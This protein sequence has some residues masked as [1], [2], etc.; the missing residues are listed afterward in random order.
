MTV[1]EIHPVPER[2]PVARDVDGWTAVMGD[3]AKLA[4]Y[5]ADT[6]LVPA[7]LRGRPAAIAA[8]IL[9]GRE[10]GLPPMTALR[11]SYV[12]AGRVGI[13]AETM[14][15]LVLAAGHEIVIRESTGSR[16]VAAGRR[17]DS[18]RWQE[19]E[20]SL[21]VARRAGISLGSGS[22]SK[23]PRQMLKARATAELCRD[24][25]PDVIGGYEA[26][27]E[28]T[29]ETTEPEAEART[30]VRRHRTGAVGARQDGSAKSTGRDDGDRPAA[31]AVETPPVEPLPPVPL[32]GEPGFDG[33]PAPSSTPIPNE[34]EDAERDP[35]DWNRTAAQG[36]KIH[37]GLHEFGIRDREV[38]LGL[39]ATILGRE[40]ETTKT[41]SRSEA[42]VI[43][44][45]FTRISAS[46]Y[47]RAGLAAAIDTG[48]LAN[49]LPVEPEPALDDAAE[50]QLGPDTETPQAEPI[51]EP[52][53]PAVPTDSGLSEF[54]VPLP[55]DE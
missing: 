36:I 50:R 15:A 3:V 40:V 11:T 8:V 12:I 19:V 14:R 45:T 38:G 44:D 27:E 22:W 54:D 26:Q 43:L 32:P 34:N 13:A 55:L 25:F 29:S 5:V 17:R 28:I 53:P 48:D 10:I 23:Y 47:L 6:E 52:E 30:T 9:Y 1:A 33:D 2:L 42:R 46:Q 18:E 16:C 7:A 37:A 24:L 21:D 51:Q 20:W 35:G 39:L 41:I 31:S 49:W 4:T